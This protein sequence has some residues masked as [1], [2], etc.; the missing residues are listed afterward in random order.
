M[1][2]LVMLVALCATAA[3]APA[4]QKPAAPSAN[5]SSFITGGGL[6]QTGNDCFVVMTF[7]N[8]QGTKVKVKS[9]VC[10]DAV[11]SLAATPTPAPKA[12]AAKPEEKK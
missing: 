4:Y 9:Q 3:C 5:L 1:K 7:R 8:N 6:V 10:A 2:K 11:A 12:D